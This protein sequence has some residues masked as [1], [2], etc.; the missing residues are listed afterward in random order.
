MSGSDSGIVGLL[1]LT[2][3]AILVIVVFGAIKLSAYCPN[4]G[5]WKLLKP[6]PK[7][8]TRHKRKISDPTSDSTGIDPSVDLENGP[9]TEAE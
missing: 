4:P 6:W 2:P 3:I 5:R 7:A 8:E 1:I 9:Q